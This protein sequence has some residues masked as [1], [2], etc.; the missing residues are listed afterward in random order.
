MIASPAAAAASAQPG[1]PAA[2]SYIQFPYL[3]SIWLK[4]KPLFGGG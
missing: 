1:M 4:A 2:V 3:L